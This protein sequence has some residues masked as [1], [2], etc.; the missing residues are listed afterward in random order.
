MS[1]TVSARSIEERAADAVT[2]LKRG[3]RRVLSQAI[4]AVEEDSPVGRAISRIARPSAGRAICV[5]FTGSPGV[6]KSTLVSAFVTAMR[7]RNTRVAVLAVDPSSPYS[8]GSILGDRIRMSVH[9]DDEGV[10][11]RS[12]SSRDSLGGLAPAAEAIVDLLDLAGWEVVILETVGA[13]QSA[14]EIVGRAD[15]TVVI[16]APGFGDDIQALKAGILEIADILVV[17]KAEL[18]G[19]SDLLRQLRAAVKL[20]RGDRSEIAVLLTTATNQVGVDEL[21][22]AVDDRARGRAASRAGR[23]ADALRRTLVDQATT[24]LRRRALSDA[25]GSAARL[26]AAV[27]NGTLSITEAALGFLEGRTMN[28]QQS[29]AD[30]TFWDRAKETR[31]REEREREVLGLLQKQVTNA[32]QRIPFYRALYDAHGFK[33]E[34]LRTL[35]DFTK[36][37]PVVK[38]DMLR[39]DQAAHPPFGSYTGAGLTE[40]DFAR[41]H[42]SSGTSGKPTLYVFSQRDWSYIGDVMAQGFYTCGVRPDDRVQLATVFSLFMGGWGSLLG[43]ERI[44]ATVFPI[45]AGETERQ[46]ELMYRVGSTVLVTTP[47]YALHMLETARKLGYDPVKSPLRLGIFIGEPG[48]SIPGTRTALET[49]WGIIVRDMATTSEMTPWATNAECSAGRGVHVMQDEVWTEI[50]DRK[51][52]SL[53]LGEGQSGGVVYTHLRRESQPMI[54]FWSGDESHMTYQPCQCER[55]Y[56]RLPEGVYGRLDDMLIIR[57]TNVYPSRVQRSI[58]EVE[59]AGLEFNIVLERAGSLDEV[60][61]RVEYDAA[62]SHKG[63]ALAAFCADLGSRIQRKLKNDT[64]ITFQIEILPPETLERAISKAK[65]VFDKRPKHRPT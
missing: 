42:G 41:I 28:S 21:V 13:G 44:G 53:A 57:G 46:I 65:R 60:T 25:D 16:C 22:N 34:Q 47:T 27:E 54:R 18:P 35:E 64:A 33:P 63:E 9:S 37:V 23:R 24:W 1:V 17:N 55:T 2:A 29:R 58:L 19:A 31:S 62:T 4:S 5:G 43:C 15:V 59:G 3:D 12:I 40:L 61:V 56:P 14:V 45:G 39:D 26:C 11:I 7:R 36:R 20:R 50:V 32:Y 6:G 10:F 51:D 8:G 38:K 52:S 30:G 49:G 48:A